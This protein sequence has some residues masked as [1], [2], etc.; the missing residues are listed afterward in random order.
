MKIIVHKNQ[1][2]R[3]TEQFY[4]ELIKFMNFNEYLE[5]DIEYIEN[6]NLDFSEQ[7]GPVLINH[8][9][10]IFKGI[11]IFKELRNKL[12]VN[13]DKISVLMDFFESF[14]LKEIVF[15]LDIQ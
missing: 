8:R 5:C 1:I 11:E 12:L 2:K 15:L 3:K 10:E 7:N 9:N 6:I 14:I 13:D 4:I